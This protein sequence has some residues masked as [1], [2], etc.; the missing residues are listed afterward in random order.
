MLKLH[1]GGREKQENTFD[2]RNFVKYLH[3]SQAD[4]FQT[5]EYKIILILIFLNENF[6]R[7]AIKLRL[8][9]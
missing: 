3:K 8:I 4:C 5:L 2:F 7:K 6:T 1:T 9:N